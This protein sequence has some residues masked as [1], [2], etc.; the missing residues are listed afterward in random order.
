MHKFLS[1]IGLMTLCSVQNACRPTA[2]RR[3]TPKGTGS[4]NGAEKIYFDNGQLV[5][6]MKFSSGHT[7]TLYINVHAADSVRITIKTASDTANIRISQLFCPD[8]SADGPYGRELKYRFRDSGRYYMTVNEN[9]MIGNTYTGSYTA[10]IAV[11][12]P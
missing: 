11:I 4:Q 1:I 10:E 2:D 3:G 9:K 12:N 7:D 8:G 6:Q 5:K